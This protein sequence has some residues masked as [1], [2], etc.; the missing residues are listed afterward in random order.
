MTQI[1]YTYATTL[2]FSTGDVPETDEV[3]VEVSFTVAWGS[4]ET[5]RFGP[6]ESYDPG[7]A[8]EVED[9]KLL[10]VNGKPRP[11]GMYSGYVRNEDDEFEADVI[12]K[13]EAHHDDMLREAAEIEADREIQAQEY[14]AEARRE[15]FQ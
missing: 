12:D 4:P 2:A 9:I 14:R 3:E 11:W 1:R 7:S 15:M 8:S 13:L 10:T 5:G 6:V